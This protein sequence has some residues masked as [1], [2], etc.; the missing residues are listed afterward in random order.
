MLFS[1][2]QKNVEKIVLAYVPETR[3][4][5]ERAEYR[6]KSTF[7]FLRNG[8]KIEGQV[9]DIW[10]SPAGSTSVAVDVNNKAVGP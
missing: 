8:K 5:G 7:V 1:L 6:E 9:Y 2:K 10:L 4:F 3:M